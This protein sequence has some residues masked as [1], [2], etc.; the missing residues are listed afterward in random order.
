MYPLFQAA[1]TN[2]FKHT[3]HQT[4]ILH[5]ENSFAIEKPLGSHGIVV[6]SSRKDRV[7]R[8]RFVDFWTPIM[9][10]STN[11]KLVVPIHGSTGLCEFLIFCLSIL[12]VIH[13]EL[14]QVSL[15]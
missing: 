8:D 14:V 5:K 3:L 9:E 15:F 13:C 6:T 12:V 1:V 10:L 7:K 4:T 11:S 2:Y